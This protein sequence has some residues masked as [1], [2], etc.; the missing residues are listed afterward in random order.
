[1]ELCYFDEKSTLV[2]AAC[3]IRFRDQVE[4][5]PRSIL[6]VGFYPTPAR[7]AFLT[8]GINAECRVFNLKISESWIV[9]NFSTLEHVMYDNDVINRVT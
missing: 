7:T 4:K 1:M 6:F 8:F 5:N 9:L 2:S 3:K